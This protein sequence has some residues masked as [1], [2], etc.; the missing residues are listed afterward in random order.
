MAFLG[1]DCPAELRQAAFELLDQIKDDLEID[2]LMIRGLVD[3]E[4]R[5]DP[6]YR[7]ADNHW[8]AP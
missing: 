2:A 7:I 5:D 1:Q 6:I 8:A 4:R 3:C